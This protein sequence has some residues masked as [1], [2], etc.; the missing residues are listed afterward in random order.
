[1]QPKAPPACLQGLITPGVPF[2]LDAA[3][4]AIGEVVI[5][6]GPAPAL[7]P[8]A[9]PTATPTA[10]P[11][12][13]APA[14]VTAPPPAHEVE[15]PLAM[16]TVCWREPFLLKAIAAVAAASARHAE[17]MRGKSTPPPPPRAPEVAGVSTAQ[18]PPQLRSTTAQWLDGAQ[19]PRS[20]SQPSAAWLDGPQVI[21][22]KSGVEVEKEDDELPLRAALPPTLPLG[23]V[24]SSSVAAFDSAHRQ[25]CAAGGPLYQRTRGCIVK[26]IANSE[27]L[28]ALQHGSHGSATLA[29]A[30]QDR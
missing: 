18:P 29:L 28:P 16:E 8:N 27:G 20:V 7:T 4:S 13:M 12:T 23:A 2:F 26:A 30:L 9:T 25:R 3:A 22:G 19:V 24:S 5:Y 6:S 17:K 14:A 15:L 10:T 11:K 1:M 21:N